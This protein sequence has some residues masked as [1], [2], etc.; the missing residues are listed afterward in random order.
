MFELMYCLTPSKFQTPDFTPMER[1]GEG[2]GERI[3][4]RRVGNIREEGRKATAHDLICGNC[5]DSWALTSL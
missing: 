5:G 4:G 2:G 1:V 3:E